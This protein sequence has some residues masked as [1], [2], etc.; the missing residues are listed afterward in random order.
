MYIGLIGR[1]EGGVNFRF[2]LGLD[3]RERKRPL[4]GA[5]QGGG[6]KG[7]VTGAEV[8]PDPKDRNMMVIILRLPTFDAMQAFLGDVKLKAALEKGGTTS[9]PTAVVGLGV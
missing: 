4:R 1:L 3:S 7:R 9:A 6:R 5:S 2:I 8:F